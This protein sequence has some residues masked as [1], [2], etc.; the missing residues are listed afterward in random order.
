[1]RW[2]DT[3]G[4]PRWGGWLTASL[5]VHLAVAALFTHLF[6]AP[7]GLPALPD[8]VHAVELESW[9]PA[10][11]E[12]APPGEPA[13]PDSPELMARLGDP[14]EARRDDAADTLQD[15]AQSAGALAG[16]GRPR[17]SSSPLAGED[18]DDLR[19]RPM[20]HPTRQTPNRIRTDRRAV[21]PDNRRQTPNPALSPHLGSGRA[22]KSPWRTRARARGWRREAERLTARSAS[23]GGPDLPPSARSDE[24]LSNA[25]GDERFTRRE[26]RG[27]AADAFRRPELDRAPPTTLTRRI[28]L[29]L[30]DDRIRHQASR[31]RFPD[32]MD[33][34]RS[35]GQ[36]RASGKGAGAKAGRRGDPEGADRGPSIWLNNPDHRYLRYFRRVHSKIQPLWA[37]PKHLEVQM[38]QGDVL[39]RFTIRADGKVSDVRI[40]K[41]SGYPGFDRRVVAAIRKAAPFG[42]IPTGLGERVKVLAPFEFNNPLVR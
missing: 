36:G 14:G 18:L 15:P 21:S 22:G 8:P 20:N 4:A 37:F 25:P 24:A 42:P 26:R 31:Q 11:Q 35:S 29:D 12:L 23:P 27:Q 13:P 9:S 40:A 19:F 33:T 38:V 1:M 16:E 17:P 5:L 2:T 6:M 10:R 7:A 41:S 34:A 39:V 30:A 32:L 3:Q 28:D